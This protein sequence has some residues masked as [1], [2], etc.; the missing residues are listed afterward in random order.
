MIHLIKSWIGGAGQGAGAS[1]DVADQLFRPLPSGGLGLR[2]NLHSFMTE[3]EACLEEAL[4]EEWLLQVRE[5]IIGNSPELTEVK[6]NWMERELKRYFFMTALVKKLPLYSVDAE[7]VWRELEAFT[8]NYQQFCEK[9]AGYYLQ[10]QQAAPLGMQSIEAKSTRGCFELLYGSLFKLEPET[11][12]LIGRFHQIK[13]DDELL[14]AL[15]G[16]SEPAHS[17]LQSE[18]PLTGLTSKVAERDSLCAALGLL[19]TAHEDKSS[20]IAELTASLRQRYTMAR[21]Y[22]SA[23]NSADRAHCCDES[24]PVWVQ[25]AYSLST[26]QSPYNPLAPAVKPISTSTFETCRTGQ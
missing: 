13:L 8:L 1:M 22:H 9:F 12:L 7:R 14:V 5:R 16:T 25:V 26:E 11:Q 10:V 15:Q 17:E 23:E 3:M 6:Y 24:D 20:A 21:T 2:E 18:N 19:E 4:P